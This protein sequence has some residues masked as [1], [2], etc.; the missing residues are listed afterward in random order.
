MTNVERFS[1]FWRDHSTVS[2]MEC[3]ARE[4]HLPLY[5]PSR[6]PSFTLFFSTRLLGFLQALVTLGH[7]V[8]VSSHTHSAVDNILV[9]LKCIGVDFIRI[10]TAANVHREI[11]DRVLGADGPYCDTSTSALDRMQK[12]I[13]VVTANQIGK[14]VD[15]DPSTVSGWCDLS[16]CSASASQEDAI[17]CVHCGRSMSDSV[18]F[19]TGS[20][21]P[22]PFIH[23]GGRSYAASSSRF[24]S[25]GTRVE[26]G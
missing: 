24:Q 6:F 25:K 21:S 9:R 5:R 7:S 11:Q 17:R 8:L 23:T 4:R 1:E 22:C 10:G 15:R 2:F 14:G 19:S 26:A 16:G 3:R 20:S 18:A 13:K 12:E